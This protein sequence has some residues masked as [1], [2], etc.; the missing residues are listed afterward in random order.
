MELKCTKIEKVFRSLIILSEIIAILTE[1][2]IYLLDMQ[3]YLSKFLIIAFFCVSFLLM[4]FS[5]F[6]I[7]S[8]FKYIVEDFCKIDNQRFIQAG[9]IYRNNLKFLVISVITTVL[10]MLLI[11][12]FKLF[13]F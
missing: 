4:I 6:Y 13:I 11:L 10:I 3:Q 2:L 8:K 9:E 7:V 5:Y 12:S 1:A